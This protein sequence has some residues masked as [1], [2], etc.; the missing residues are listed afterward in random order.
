MTNLT[1]FLTLTLANLILT[2]V[3]KPRDKG[4]M[5]D[6]MKKRWSIVVFRN[7]LP[8]IGLKQRYYKV[9]RYETQ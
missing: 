7:S 1:S 6:I 8:R 5:E 2:S 9:D 3:G 4:S